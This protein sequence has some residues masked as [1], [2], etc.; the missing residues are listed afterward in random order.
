MVGVC[1]EIVSLANCATNIVINWGQTG[2]VTMVLAFKAHT[3]DHH[4]H[5]RRH[6]I[7]QRMDNNKFA[8][9]FKGVTNNSI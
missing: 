5:H 8:N 2:R 9:A 7:G 1:N 4:H 3:F 6:G